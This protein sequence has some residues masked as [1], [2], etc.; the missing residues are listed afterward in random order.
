M[1]RPARRWL[2]PTSSASFR[3]ETDLTRVTLARILKECGRLDEFRVNP[4][5]FVVQVA[6]VLRSVLGD[7]LVEGIEYER[8][9]GLVWEMRQL[10]PEAGTEVERYIDHLYEIQSKGKSPYSHVEWESSVEEKFAKRLD[11]DKRVRFFVKLPSWFTID[12]PVGPYNPDWA[13]CWDE[14]DRPRLH[15]VRETKSSYEEAE[16]RGNENAKIACAREHFKAI[17]TEYGVATGFDDL[18]SQMG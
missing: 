15:L 9:D 6:R 10:E 4:H 16:R 14:E 8:I 5:A 7:E 13:I 17:G 12:T 11:G 1:P 3:T 18:V 2:C